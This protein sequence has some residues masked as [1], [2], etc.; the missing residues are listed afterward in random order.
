MTSTT[1]TSSSSSASGTITLTTSSSQISSTITPSS[2]VYITFV[3][4]TASSTVTTSITSTQVSTIITTSSYT[5]TT[6]TCTIPLFLGSDLTGGVPPL[7]V[8]FYAQDMNAAGILQYEWWFGD[9]SRI[10]GYYPAVTHT[11]QSPWNYNVFLQVTD[12]NGCTGQS[13]M[14]VIVS[15]VI[16]EFPIGASLIVTIALTLTIHLRSRMRRHPLGQQRSTQQN[17]A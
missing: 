16:P 13:N 6:T 3:T 8:T 12:A 17:R 10:S 5:P 7:T 4:C 11:Y 14:T 9:G 1:L 15:T 2:S